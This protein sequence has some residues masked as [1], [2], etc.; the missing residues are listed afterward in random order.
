MICLVGLAVL[1]VL[2]EHGEQ[3]PRATLLARRVGLAGAHDRRRHEVALK[4]GDLHHEA[5]A[6]EL[7]DERLEDHRQREDGL[8]PVADPGQALDQLTRRLPDR[9]FLPRRLVRG[10]LEA[11]DLLAQREVVEDQVLREAQLVDRADAD[12]VVDHVRRCITLRRRVDVHADAVLGVRPREHVVGENL[13][14][15]R[16]HGLEHVRGA[17]VLDVLA[18]LADDVRIVAIDRLLPL[19]VGIEEG[20]PVGRLQRRPF[21]RVAAVAVGERVHP[22]L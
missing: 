5:R 3:R 7:A 18:D 12:R 9:V 6:E 20:V 4:R 1:G 2:G 14:P 10:T 11:L 21:L 13:H 16:V 15:G 8:R 19:L 22:A 17:P